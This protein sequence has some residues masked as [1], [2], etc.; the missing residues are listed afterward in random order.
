MGFEHAKRPRVQYT[1]IFALARSEEAVV[2]STMYQKPTQFCLQGLLRSRAYRYDDDR[3][4]GIGAHSTWPWAS[5]I[6]DTVL[7]AIVVNKGVS[8]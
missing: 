8:Q 3:R 1:V 2:F 7:V 5:A 6:L 4:I